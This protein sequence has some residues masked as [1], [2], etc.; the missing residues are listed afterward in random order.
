MEASFPI[1]TVRLLVGFVMAGMLGLASCGVSRA[2]PPAHPE[3]EDPA[4]VDCP[5]TSDPVPAA[6]VEVVGPLDEAESALVTWALD[7]YSTA[8][9]MLPARLQ[10]IFDPTRVAC[11][12]YVGYCAPRSDPPQVRVCLPEPENTFHALGREMTLLHELAHLWHAGE[13]QQGRLLDPSGI[14]GGQP[15]SADVVWNDRAEERLAGVI[16]WG[17]MDQLRRPVPLGSSCADL[18]NQ[19]EALTGAAPLGP[20][21][22]VCIPTAS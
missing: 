21:E 19:F 12:G 2:G 15:Q 18:F 6:R 8:G 16:T 20:L 10:V 14:V 13:K 22:P 3:I 9:L 7:R 5:P 1:R 11:H 17:L 4:V